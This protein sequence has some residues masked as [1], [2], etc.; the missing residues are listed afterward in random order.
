MPDEPTADLDAIA[1]LIGDDTLDAC[2]DGLGPYDDDETAALRCL[3]P[4]GV[5]VDYGTL[6]DRPAS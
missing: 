2:E 5:P 3:F 6:L 4:D 1:A